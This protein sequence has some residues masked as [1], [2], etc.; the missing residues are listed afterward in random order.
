MAGLPAQRVR[1][2]VP[3]PRAETAGPDPATRDAF[4]ATMSHELRT[5]LAAALG[6]LELLLDGVAGPL[7]AEQ[8]S[9][10]QAAQSGAQ[11]MLRLVEDLLL[12][13]GAGAGDGQLH[14]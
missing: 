13:S 14:L 7:S 3:A 10:A 12:V 1:G 5:P 6:G 11:R 9:V 2:D 4:L 8:E